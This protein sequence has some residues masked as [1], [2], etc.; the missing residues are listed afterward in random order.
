MNRSKLL[1]NLK[2]L[3]YPML[4]VDES[5]NANATL[6]E[7]VKTEDL[8]FWESFPLLLAGSL[9]KNL[10]EYNKVLRQ[11]KDSKDK[12]SF[13]DLIM[14]SLA[15]YKYLELKLSYVD[16]LYNSKYFKEETFNRYLN[17]F[18]KKKNLLSNENQLSPDRM[19]NTFR[20]YFSH[21]ELDLKEY[22]NTKDEF[23]LEY[24]M[25]QVFSS[26]QKELFLKKLK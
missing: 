12:S 5:I 11:L 2:A 23:E 26:K 6:A 22:I 4:E 7:V 25:S 20:N 21:A 19:L 8:R 10:F 13:Q 1:E 14:M 18:K 9:E 17:S 15:L 24:S 3:G 16:W